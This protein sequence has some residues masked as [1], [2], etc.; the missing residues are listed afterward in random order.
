[1]HVGCLSELEVSRGD[2]GFAISG[3]TLLGAKPEEAFIYG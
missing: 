3:L 2:V 1:M